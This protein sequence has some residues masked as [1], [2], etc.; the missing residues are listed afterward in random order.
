M[1]SKEI[2]IYTHFSF[3]NAKQNFRMIGT[4]CHLYDASYRIAFIAASFVILIMFI[5]IFMLSER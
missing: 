5:S 1:Y 4:D 3:G 2:Y